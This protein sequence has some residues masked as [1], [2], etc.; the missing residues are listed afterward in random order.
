LI[1]QRNGFIVNLSDLLLDLTIAFDVSL[2][3]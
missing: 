2:A 3:T 1:L